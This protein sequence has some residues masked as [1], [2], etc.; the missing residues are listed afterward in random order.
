MI[1]QAQEE[2]PLIHY[3][4]TTPEFIPFN[5]NC[6]CCNKPKGTCAC[7]ESYCGADSVYCGDHDKYQKRAEQAVEDRVGKLVPIIQQIFAQSPPCLKQ[8]IEC[9]DEA[10]H[11]TDRDA[12]ARALLRIIY[13]EV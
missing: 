13:E 1:Q 8:L 12:L 9:A 10:N 11:G 3:G 2:T 6:S 4:V 5:F 7:A